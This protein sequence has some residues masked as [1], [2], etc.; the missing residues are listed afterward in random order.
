M[1][2]QLVVFHGA[3]PLEF[4]TPTIVRMLT[5]VAVSNSADP[6]FVFTSIVK[7]LGGGYQ[8]EFRTEIFKHKREGSDPIIY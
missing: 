2:A 8:R 7:W 5:I 3:F 4:L 1:H 6:V